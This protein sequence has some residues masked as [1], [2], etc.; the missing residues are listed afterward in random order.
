MA[1]RITRI[2]IAPPRPAHSATLLVSDQM[3][4]AAQFGVSVQL[5]MIGM[6]LDG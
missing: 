3:H 5:A 6:K 1:P 4:H 2:S